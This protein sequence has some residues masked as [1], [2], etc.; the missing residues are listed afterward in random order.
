M[1][2]LLTRR[3][4][5]RETAT[6]LTFFARRLVKG[7]GEG[8]QSI[9]SL[10]LIAVALLWMHALAHTQ[11][12]RRILYGVS[13]SISHLPV[14]VGKDTGLFAKNGLNIEPVQIRGGAVST[15]AIMSGQAV[16]S[17][18]GAG[19]VVAARVEGGD[20][21]L[22]ACPADLEPV[23]LIARPEIKSPAELKGKA[24]G[25][26]RLNSSIHFYL[27]SATRMVGI[28]SDKEMTLLQLGGSAE[29]SAALEA[30]RIA[31]AALTIKDVLPFTQRGWPVLADLTKSDL[32]YP[33]SC[34]T[35]TRAFVKAEPKVVNA[36][37]NTY[38]SAIRL[39]KTD[40]KL[41]ERSLLKWLKEKES[42]TLSKSLEAFIRLFK[43]I[44][45]VPDKGIENILK[46]LGLQRP[47]PN[48]FIGHPE[49]FRDNV[50]L[51]RAL[52]KS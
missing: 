49:L 33:S 52:P 31:A 29:I 27:R 15:M 41:A 34:V 22:L 37:L 13:T 19:S 17:G 32:V 28:D 51:E 25:V 18:V 35:S 50:P 38:V 21:V 40:Q 20:I 8:T 14:W 12:S 45:Y 30:G 2:N 43:P 16:L 47:V 39:I 11:E 6:S 9:F 7:K 1:M 5:F 4:R 44:P 26:T 48:A 46:D 3:S 24:A 10:L 23:Y 42:P 36:F